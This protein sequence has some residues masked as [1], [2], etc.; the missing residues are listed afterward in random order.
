M[1]ENPWGHRFGVI[2]RASIV[3]IIAGSCSTSE[4]NGSSNAASNADRGGAAT[5]DDAPG[6]QWTV[7]SAKAEGFDQAALDAIAADAERAGSNCLLVTRHGRIVD[8]W[9]WNGTDE[10]SSQE[11]FSAT[12]SI[13]STLVGIA[14][15]KRELSIEDSAAKFIPEWTATPSTAVTVKNILSNDS[16]REWSLKSDYVTM[17]RSGDLTRYAV[18]LGQQSPPGETWAYNNAAIQTLSE[19]IENASGASATEIAEQR[20]FSKIGMADTTMNPDAAGNTLTF[21]GAHSTCRDLARF[22]YLFLRKGTWNGEQIVSE[23]WVEAA[24]GEPSQ[25]LNAAYGYLWWLNRRGTVL[26][27][28]I[29][30]TAQESEAREDSQMVPGAPEDMY[31][32][33]GKGNQIVSVDP[34]TDTVAVR[35]GVGTDPAGVEPFGAAA[36][37]RVVTD[38]I[39]PS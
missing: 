37:A 15:D 38:A 34:G 20:L 39:V 33:I 12:K 27:P 4:T 18:G 8:E 9:Y 14:Q 31:W 7:S 26:S 23:D 6:E 21:M 25:S 3:A 13:A 32:A 2:A 17:I 1:S 22:G 30:A 19:V 28:L 24:T 5:A 35:L 36:I 29:A 10:H 11:I 16:G